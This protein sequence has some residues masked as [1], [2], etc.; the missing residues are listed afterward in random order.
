MLLVNFIGNLADNARIMQG[1]S[2]NY[3]SFRA[4]SNRNYKDPKTGL[5]ATATTWVTVNI[6]SGYENLAQ[7]LLKGTK[8]FVLGYMKTDI[9]RDKAQV[10][11]VGITITA[12]RVELCSVPQNNQQQ[13]STH[14]QLPQQQ[15]PPQGYQQQPPQNNQQQSPQ[16]YQQQPPQGYQQQPRPVQQSVNMPYTP[17]DRQILEDFANAG[18]PI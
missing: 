4:A 10:A 1:N 8:V 13:P 15:Q 18:G 6:N 14:G 11:Q 12:L 16:G 5:V 3:C 7:Y 17:I 9:Y 2:G